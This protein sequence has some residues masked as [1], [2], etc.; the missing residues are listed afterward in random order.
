MQKIKIQF[1]VSVDLEKY[2]QDNDC[3]KSEAIE[4]I[5]ELVQSAGTHELEVNE[6]IK[7]D[8]ITAEQV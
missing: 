5:K 4:L 2:M 6:Y 7:R 8:L 1:T 3:T